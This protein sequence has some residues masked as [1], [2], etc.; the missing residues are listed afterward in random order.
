[1]TTIDSVCVFCGSKHGVDGAYEEAAR[2]LGSAIAQRA[3]RLV[4]GGGIGRWPDEDLRT[5]F[6]MGM[7][8]DGDFVGGLMGEVVDDTTSRLTR[9]D[10]EA[11]IAYLRSVAPV[12]N[13]VDRSQG[14]N[15]ARDRPGR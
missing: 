9:A 3:I 14:K 4:Y 2:A 8:P 5:L 10:R 12:R 13:R 7:T 6:E 15:R 11:I 1:M